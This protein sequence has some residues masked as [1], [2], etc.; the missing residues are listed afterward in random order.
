MTPSFSPTSPVW[1][2]PAQTLLERFIESRLPGAAKNTPKTSAA[3]MKDFWD[4]ASAADCI[5]GNEAEA[6]IAEDEDMLAATHTGH[7]TPMQLVSVEASLLCARLAQSLGPDAA[8]AMAQDG[9]LTVLQTSSASDQVLLADILKHAFFPPSHTVIRTLQSAPAPD[10]VQL[11]FYPASTSSKTSS[12]VQTAVKT[13]EEAMGLRTPLIVLLP[14]DAVLP[15]DLRGALPA[16]L[17]LG[18]ITR[19][20]LL[21]ALHNT[22]SRTGRVDRARLL[23][24]LPE[25]AALRHISRP[26]ILAAFRAPTTIKV[27][28]ALAA[29]VAGPTGRTPLQDLE[30]TGELYETAKTLVADMQ[31]YADGALP[32]A[33]IPRGLLLVGAPGTGKTF[34]AKCIAEA[35]GLPFITATFGEW[36]AAGHLGNMLA[37]MRESFAAAAAAA[38]CLMFIDEMDSA[39]SRS[40][41]D[42]HGASYRQQVINEFLAL[43]D[44]VGGAEGIMLICATNHV[45]AIDPAILRPGRLDTHITV[46]MPG[47]KALEQQLRHHLGPDWAGVDFGALVKA[48]RGKT[49]A[50]LAGAIRKAR[51]AARAQTAPLTEDHLLAALKPDTPT[52]P[53]LRWRVSVHEAGHAIAAQALGL[54]AVQEMSIANGGGHILMTTVASDAGIA[55]Y[56][57][58]IAHSLAGRCAEQLILGQASGGAGGG[59]DSDLARATMLAL[60]I[61]RGSG[62]GLNGLLWEPLPSE[63]AA[64]PVSPDERAA[65]QRRLGSQTLRMEAVLHRHRP[66]LTALA[67]ALNE[68]GHMNGEEIV[69]YLVGLRDGVRNRHPDSDV[70]TVIPL[71]PRPPFEPPHLA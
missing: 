51:T 13:L 25:D 69:P 16:P 67:K 14:A 20:T 43:I 65:I 2:K 70:P 23:A 32:W 6:M 29:R 30:G 46:P 19:E 50:D 27:A 41:S 49:P 58:H 63:S 34:A 3:Q 24:L 55:A 42:Q 52:H 1:T 5:N 56:N 60:H 15:K 17:S 28:K 37:S 61:E 4:N 10:T 31:A 59:Q 64:R 7:S 68:A 21:F 12:E 26:Q 38:P 40:A 39:G 47:P 44:G 11:V 45:D 71:A 18:P 22:H 36:Q 62:L 54:G 66:A 35:C 57:N 8:Q 53:E 48:A 33:E 9:A